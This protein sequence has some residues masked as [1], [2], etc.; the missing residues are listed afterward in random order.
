[1]SQ[2][3]RS[4][5]CTL[6]SGSDWE[7]ALRQRA[8]LRRVVPLASG[9]DEAPAI[10]VEAAR[11]ALLNER[12]GPNRLCGVVQGLADLLQGRR[13]LVGALDAVAPAGIGDAEQNRV[14]V[15]S[16]DDRNLLREAVR[17]V[18]VIEA[19]AREQALGAQAPDLRAGFARCGC[20]RDRWRG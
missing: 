12:R 1:M 6:V 2:G 20:T 10:P 4:H 9:V 19:V 15:T 13:K 17:I 8:V 5:K 16:E 7:S 14:I 3:S 18:V 11:F